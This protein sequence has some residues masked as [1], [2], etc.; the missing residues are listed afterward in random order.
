M[1]ATLRR[2][3]RF[4]FGRDHGLPRSPEQKKAEPEPEEHT[5]GQVECPADKPTTDWVDRVERTTGSG[6]WLQERLRSLPDEQD[7]RGSQDQGRGRGR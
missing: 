6:D 5:H 3:L 1:F 4:L 2:L 7:A